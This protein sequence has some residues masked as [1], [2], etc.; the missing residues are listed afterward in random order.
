MAIGRLNSRI[1]TVAPG[2]PSQ[3]PAFIVGTLSGT[4]IRMVRHGQDPRLRAK[5]HAQLQD[6]PQRELVLSA[7]YVVPR[8]AG[9]QATFGP[10][11]SVAAPAVPPVGTTPPGSPGGCGCG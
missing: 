8:D 10:G 1:R 6:V 5:L 4:T 3:G 7:P 9:G 2:F 11:G